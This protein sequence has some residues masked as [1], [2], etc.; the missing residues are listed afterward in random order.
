MTEQQLVRAAELVHTRDEIKEFLATRDPQSALV[1]E[2]A[3]SKYEFQ[4]R[5]AKKMP[6]VGV[7]EIT[8][9]DAKRCDKVGEPDM[10][11]YWFIARDVLENALRSYLPKVEAE[12]AS[13][14]IHAR[15]ATR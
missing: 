4:Q 7:A 12:L 11:A 8:L 15:K 14:G 13:L 5:E 9:V 10:L 1:Q 2:Y 3:K 6:K